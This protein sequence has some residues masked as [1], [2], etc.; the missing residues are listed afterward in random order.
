[1]KKPRNPKLLRPPPAEPAAAAAFDA[2]LGSFAGVV[3]F[4]KVG[5]IL[6]LD[7][8]TKTK[9]CAGRIRARGA[10]AVSLRAAAVD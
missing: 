9:M 1:M 5:Q 4:L 2:C 7:H 3:L 10:T 6:D 8:Q